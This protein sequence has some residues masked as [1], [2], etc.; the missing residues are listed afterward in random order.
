MT[1]VI[2]IYNKHREQ[3]TRYFAA[4]GGS[5]SKVTTMITT[6]MI[7]VSVFQV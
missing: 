2:R 3:V 7:T 5:R 4:G 1:N 6:T